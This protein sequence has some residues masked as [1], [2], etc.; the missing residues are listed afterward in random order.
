MRCHRR[1]V[2]L[3]IFFVAC[4]STV[5]I[6][7][8]AGDD[9]R[10]IE[11]LEEAYERAVR[12]QDR[13]ALEELLAD[14]FVATSSRAELRDKAAEIADIVPP[15]AAGWT[16]EQFTLSEVVV[17]PVGTAAIAT[18]RSELTASGPNGRATL[19]FRFMRVY[20]QRNGKWRIVTQQ[21]TRIPQQ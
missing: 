18:G 9:A 1:I 16:T 14:D 5:R 11:A 8:T 12:D 20:A 21:L 2:A 13:A 6:A 15:A 17:R 7:T 4:T 3:S 19:R 10:A